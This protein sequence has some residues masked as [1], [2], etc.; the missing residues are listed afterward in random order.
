MVITSPMS[1]CAP[2]WILGTMV[3]N[4]PMRYLLVLIFFEWS[5]NEALDQEFMACPL[6]SPDI[7]SPAHIGEV[8]IPVPLLDT[9]SY[10]SIYWCICCQAV[11]PIHGGKG[12][13]SPSN[14]YY[15]QGKREV[16]VFDF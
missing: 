16:F 9:P 10:N 6:Q 15:V 7:I 11:T 14:A 3:L 5:Y 8:W 2:S 4:D 13:G 12:S 1:G